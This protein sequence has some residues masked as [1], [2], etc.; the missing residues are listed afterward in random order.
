MFTPKFKLCLMITN[1]KFYCN[2][3]IFKTKESFSLQI[4]ENKIKLL[5]YN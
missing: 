3:F 1:K 5:I 4:I 2:V